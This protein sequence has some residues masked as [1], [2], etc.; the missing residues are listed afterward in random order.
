MACFPSHPQRYSLHFLLSIFSSLEKQVCG[1]L[2]ILDFMDIIS[3]ISEGFKAHKPAS[4]E[5]LDACAACGLGAALRAPAPLLRWRPRGILKRGSFL[6]FP[7]EWKPFPACSPSAVSSLPFSGPGLFSCLPAPLLHGQSPPPHPGRPHCSLTPGGLEPALA[8]V[9]PPSSPPLPEAGSKS[10]VGR[11]Q[12][13]A[14]P[15]TRHPVA[16]FMT[17]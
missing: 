5:A 9:G 3:H 6:P 1:F 4:P 11:L 8:R 16:G 14:P 2:A 10:R 13:P 7:E 17:T 15:R 12:S